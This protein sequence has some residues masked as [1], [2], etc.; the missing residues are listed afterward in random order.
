VPASFETLVAS[1]V[2]SG[3]DLIVGGGRTAGLD[4]GYFHDITI[5]DNVDNKSEIAHEE[6]FGP[7]G[8]IIGFDTDEQA[9][10]LANDSRFGLSGSVISADAATAFDIARPIRTGS[11]QINGGM[12]KMAYGPLGGF[13]RSGLGREFGPEWLKEYTQEKSIY[14]PIGY[15]KAI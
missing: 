2:A 4:K 1:G 14:Y 12:G 15:P 7:V 6:V 8:V 5:F 9:I 11:M 3:A 10:D 13:K